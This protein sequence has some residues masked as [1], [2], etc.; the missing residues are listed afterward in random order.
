MLRTRLLS[1]C[2]GTF[3]DTETTEI[4][5]REEADETLGRLGRLD[6]HIIWKIFDAKLALPQYKVERIAGIPL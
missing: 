3:V 2:F 6:R 4:E 1:G 5:S